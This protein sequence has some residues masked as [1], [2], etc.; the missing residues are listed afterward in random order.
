MFINLSL[1]L[2]KGS[3]GSVG[4]VLSAHPHETR[5]LFLLQL[6]REK[7]EGEGK[8]KGVREGK[9]KS[10]GRKK[11]KQ[12]STKETAWPWASKASLTLK[13]STSSRRRG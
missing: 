13:R 12:T 10:W 4:G 8:R 3:E 2:L 5:L 1:G 6:K 11:G 9:D 7:R